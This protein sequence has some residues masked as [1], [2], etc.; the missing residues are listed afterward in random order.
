L[1]LLVALIA[2]KNRLNPVLPI[3]VDAIAGVARVI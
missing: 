3:A 2:L 1:A